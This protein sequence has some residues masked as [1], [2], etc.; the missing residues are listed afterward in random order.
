MNTV[1][2]AINRGFSAIEI[3]SERNVNYPLN[4]EQKNVI[5]CIEKL[6]LVPYGY[7]FVVV[8]RA[9]E[10]GIDIIDPRFKHLIVDSFYQ[11]DRIQAAR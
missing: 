3:H 1:R 5:D 7:N 4:D 11:Q 9:F 10:R 8:T 2:A 6:H